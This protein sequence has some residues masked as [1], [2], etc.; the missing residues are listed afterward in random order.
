MFAG[1]NHDQL[2]F[3]ANYERSDYLLYTGLLVPQA[4]TLGVELSFYAIAPIILRN[5][6]ILL[7]LLTASLAT[8]TALLWIGL[9]T[10]DPW[11]YRFFP[12]ELS[13]FILGA[14]SCQAIRSTLAIC[15]SSRPSAC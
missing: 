3:A 7:R 1:V 5:K 11:T 9:G 2:V 10:Q 4:W 15:W 14:L 6:A 12:A 13:L 8:R